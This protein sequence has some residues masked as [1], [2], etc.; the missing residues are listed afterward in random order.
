MAVHSQGRRRWNSH[1][2]RTGG[3]DCVYTD[4]VTRVASR[5]IR[6]LAAFVLTFSDGLTHSGI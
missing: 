1:D 2:N 3:R 4:T 6:P 5:P